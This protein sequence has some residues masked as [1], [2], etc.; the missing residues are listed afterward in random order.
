M[1]VLV[2]GGTRYVGRAV[3]DA[4]LARGD[5]V[6]VLNRGVSRPAP[7]GALPLVADRTDPRALRRA[8]GD[9]EWDAVVDT[10]MGAPRVV[11]DTCALLAGRARHFGF[12]SSWVVYER[13]LPPGADESA[14]VIG[15]DP[16][17]EEHGFYPTA[18]RGAELAALEAFGDHALIARAGPTLGPREDVGTMTWWMRRIERGGAILAPGDP[19]DPLRYVDVRDLAS[20]MLDAADRDVGGTFTTLSPRGRH[21]MGEYL[22]TMREVVGSDAELVWV[23]DEMVVAAGIRP[24]L[25]IPMWLPASMRGGMHEIDASAARRAGLDTGRPLRDTLAD[26]W[27]W[28]RAE[29]EPPWQDTHRWLDPHVERRVLDQVSRAGGAQ[30]R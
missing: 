10:W 2:L 7:A 15:G 17:D 16:G 29:G 6:T 27:A 21:T 8:L 30:P 3:V 11:R 12:V 13:P 4:A 1:K 23:P 24:Y 22:D 20:W 14:A 18:K 5:E 28:L 25:D 9:R 19:S 26:G